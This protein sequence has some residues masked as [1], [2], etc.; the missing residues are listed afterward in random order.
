MAIENMIDYGILKDIPILVYLDTNIFYHILST[1][2]WLK[3]YWLV[4]YL[5]LWK[6][7]EFVSWDHEIPNWMESHKIWANYNI[8]R[9]P[10]SCGHKKGMI[11]QTL[12]MIPGFG[13]TGFG[14][15]QIYPDMFKGVTIHHY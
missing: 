3:I 1:P 8:S 14:R 13:R 4:V 11:S 5:P 15:D 6:M 7:M 10:E 12:T 9:S 2:G